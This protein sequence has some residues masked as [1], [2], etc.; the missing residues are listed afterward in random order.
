MR[1]CGSIAVDTAGAALVPALLVTFILALATS[2]AACD[3]FS[4]DE[5][6]PTAPGEPPAPA[7]PAPLPETPPTPPEA[8][9]P[10]SVEPGASAASPPTDEPTATA[11][12]EAPAPVAE[13][14]PLLYDTFN[15]TGAVSEPGHYAFLADAHDPS[16][17]VT[18]YEALRNGTTTALLIHT[19]DAHGVSQTE[20]YAAVAPGDLFEWRQADDCFV[21]YQVAEVQPDPTG[22]VPQ[23]LL[24]VAWMTYAF[25]GCTGTIATTTAA[26]LDWSALPDLG[27]TALATPVVHGIY[28]IVPAGWTGATKERELQSPPVRSTPA[29]TTDLAIART[30]DLWRDP[31]LPEG[32]VLAWATSDG[33]LGHGPSYG[34]TARYLTEP[35]QYH[36]RLQRFA[37]FD[38]W[39]YYADK[40]LS[41]EDAAWHD[42]ASVSETRVIAGRP[43]RVIY[44]PPGPDQRDLF[45]VT[46]WVF[47]PAT[48][49]EYVVFGI[50]DSLNGGNVEAVIAIARSLFEP[51]NLP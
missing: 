35:R 26:T 44:S 47:D 23:K 10:E 32:W 9:I 6:A 49:S 16:S 31:A 15:P 39:G 37:A 7:T 42:G 50:D 8:P 17:V 38:I 51:P 28:Q 24:A 1:S 30:L 40:R 3:G 29:V 14:T 11:S 34:Y 19:H 22:A 18:T 20:L 45:P 48:E 36:G 4:D 43:A 13:T 2:L 33:E 25:T 12:E 5:P 46:V 27:G 41:P 21:R